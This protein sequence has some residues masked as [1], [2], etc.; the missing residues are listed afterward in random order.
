MKVIDLGAATAE[1]RGGPV[2]RYI[3]PGL[4]FKPVP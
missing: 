1:T 3:D 4:G 2:A